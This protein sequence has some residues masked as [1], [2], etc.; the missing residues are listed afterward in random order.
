LQNQVSTLSQS[1]SELQRELDKARKSLDRQR[2]EHDKARL[3]WQD[4][5]SIRKRESATPGAG[6][7]NG[8]GHATP[9]GKIEEVSQCPCR[10]GDR[11]DSQDLK[12]SIPGPSA[13]VQLQDT[14]KLE[15][16]ADTRLKD[17]NALREKYTT[18]RQEH[19]RLRVESTSPTEEVVRASPFFQVY[20]Q[21]LAFQQSRADD[22]QQHVALNDKKLDD[23]R[24]TNGDFRDAVVNEARQE[25]D[26]LRQFSSKKDQDSARLRG[27]R[28]EIQA[29]LTERTAR[30]AE[31]MQS[32][33]EFEALANTR[34]ERINFLSSEVRR[35]KG[36]LAAQ[37]GS[38]GYLAFLKGDGGIDGDYVADLESKVS[39]V[40]HPCSRNEL[41][42]RT[43]SAQIASLTSQ[44]DGSASSVSEAE[45]EETRR[46]LARYQRVLGPN[47]EAA[48]DVRQ[49]AERLESADKD[50][51]TLR[52]QLEESEAATNALYTEVEGLS[53]L[54][55]DLDSK[56]RSKCFELKDGELKLQRLITEVSHLPILVS[57]S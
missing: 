52:L 57:R 41:I 23:L 55:E 46:T 11:A 38:E 51:K 33:E 47:P 21:R 48:E 36:K 37:D 35:L 29:E 5:D 17:V 40:L 3:E 4:L 12:P 28:D 22:L 49:L 7:T 9:N 13:D 32:I 34:Q 14:S 44:L 15:K 30:E 25:I 8:S 27:Q 53:K 26:A 42:G 50:N 24:Q 19:D 54:Y 20:L 16:L 39:Y 31:K 43:A 56:V 45:L 18:L 2:M 6:K 10:D 1:N